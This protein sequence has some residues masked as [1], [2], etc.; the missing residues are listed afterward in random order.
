MAATSEGAEGR[1]IVDVWQRAVE[2]NSPNAAFLEKEGRAW[3]E[4]GWREADERID[5]LA[6]GF[7]AL[8]LR[9]GDK[10]AILSRT[11][12]EWTLC[13]YALASIGAVVVPIYQTNSRE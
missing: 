4:V 1:T 5:Q 10:V 11:R 8:G 9:K 13:D 3:R 12:L 7:L 6:A 2:R